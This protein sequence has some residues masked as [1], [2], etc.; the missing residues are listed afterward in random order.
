MQDLCKKYNYRLMSNS[1]DLILKLVSYGWW[2]KE[3]KNT[4][5]LTFNSSFQTQNAVLA[6]NSG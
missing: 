5:I 4:R 6:S 2:G 3:E 1:K